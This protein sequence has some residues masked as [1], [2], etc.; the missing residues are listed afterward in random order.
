MQALGT[1]PRLRLAKAPETQWADYLGLARSFGQY[2]GAPR[3]PLQVAIKEG[4]AS[5][6]LAL[7]LCESR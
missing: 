4:G 7:L 2:G 1:V 5:P 3:R 6:F